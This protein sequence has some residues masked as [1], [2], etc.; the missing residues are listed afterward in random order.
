MFSAVF[1]TSR[2]TCQRHWHR[3]HRSLFI[4][5]VLAFGP[6]S[7][8][9]CL[10]RSWILILRLLDVSPC[11]VVSAS[12]NGM[13]GP[14]WSH[15]HHVSSVCKADDAFRRLGD[16]CSLSPMHSILE[17]SGLRLSS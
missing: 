6:Q 17:A 2:L 16:A 15:L 11:I 1:A 13:C 14:R 9:T 3:S 4:F 7:R 8:R 10:S 5:L 12:S